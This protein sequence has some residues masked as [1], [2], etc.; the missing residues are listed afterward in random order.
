VREAI[1]AQSPAWKA[2]KHSKLPIEGGSLKRPP[3]GFP[4]EHPYLED[5]KRTDFITSI[6]FTEKEICDAR[7]LANFTAACKKMSP[8]V[9]FVSQS[10]GLL[11]TAAV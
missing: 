10:L 5:L 11:W 3:R 2:I 7:F 9:K 8:L 4:A 1:A 6:R